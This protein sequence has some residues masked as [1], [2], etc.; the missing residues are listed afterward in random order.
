MEKISDIHAVAAD[1]G[2]NDVGSWAVV[3]ELNKKD[4]DANVRPA[5]SLCLD[6]RGNMIVSKKKFVVTVGVRRPRHRGNRRRTA[7]LPA[8]PVPGRRQ[9]GAGDGQSGAQENC[10]KGDRRASGLAAVI[11]PDALIRICVLNLR[12]LAFTLYPSAVIL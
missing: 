4:S 12:Y 8:R 10:F 6:S 2:W 7:G 11:Q 3:Y 5:H 9:S 1:I